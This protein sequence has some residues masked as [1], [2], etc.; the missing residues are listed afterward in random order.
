[1]QEC[2]REL[3]LPPPGDL[4]HP[5]TEPMSPVSLAL[6]GSFF[7]AEPPGKPRCGKSRKSNDDELLTMK[8][9]QN[10]TNKQKKLNVPQLLY[11]LIS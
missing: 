8:I 1:M 4:P 3:P 9:I 11:P 10:K 6:A 7:T 2:W 5:G